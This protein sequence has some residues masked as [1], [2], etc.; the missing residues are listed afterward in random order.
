MKKSFFTFLLIVSL[1]LP[2]FSLSL[3]SAITPLGAPETEGTVEIDEETGLLTITYDESGNIDS[4]L[5]N[6]DESYTPDDAKSTAFEEIPEFSGDTLTQFG[7]IAKLYEDYIDVSIGSPGRS[8]V[9]SS[10]GGIAITNFYKDGVAG[11]TEQGNPVFK[12]RMEVDFYVLVYTTYPAQYFYSLNPATK[13]VNWLRVDTAGALSWGDIWD[14]YYYSIEYKDY[15]T[16]SAS[17]GKLN[18]GTFSLPINV[19]FDMPTAEDRVEDQYKLIDVKSSVVSLTTSP[20]E[21]TI[22]KIGQTD[23]RYS[24]ES[25]SSKVSSYTTQ[26][27][28]TNL[29]FDSS[30]KSDLDQAISKASPGWS[31]ESDPYI[32]SDNVMNS[33]AMGTNIRLATGTDESIRGNFDC[34]I[35]AAAYHLQNEIEINFAHIRVDTRGP[36]TGAAVMASSKHTESRT[37]AVGVDNH[38]IKQRM[39]TMIEIYSEVEELDAELT[40][41]ELGEVEEPEINETIYFDNEIS[42]DEEVTIYGHEGFFSSPEFTI[43]LIGIGLLAAGLIGSYAYLKLKIFF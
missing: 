30:S 31:S 13:E 43:I 35:G 1:F 15:P 17:T 37:V 11:L 19:N 40:P 22:G 18:G 2:I 14:T 42:G 16:A 4:D 38:F 34:N 41:D 10:V 9:R 6:Q 27:Q 25:Q 23:T 32:V 8:Y 36:W 7:D 26:N 21:A 28:V 33:V 3:T 24:S 5:Y 20:D 29:D 12:Y 39:R